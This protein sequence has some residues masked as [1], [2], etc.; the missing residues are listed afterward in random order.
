MASQL[1]GVAPATWCLQQLL[2]GVNATCPT[3]YGDAGGWVEEC[4]LLN[5]ACWL[6]VTVAHR[7]CSSMVL[8]MQE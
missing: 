7:R 3:T 1:V 2:A 5:L 8:V 4:W 6:H